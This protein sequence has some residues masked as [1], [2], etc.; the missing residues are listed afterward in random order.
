[1]ASTTFFPQR[2]PSVS[3]IFSMYTS[4]SAFTILFRTILNEI[5]PTKV[6]DFIVSRFRDFFSSYFNP[7]FTFIIEERCDYV[8]NQ[9]FRAAETYLPTLIAGISTG[10]LLVRSSNLK[11]PLARPKFGIPVKAKILDDF[12][13][14]PLEWT[15]LSERNENPPQSLPKR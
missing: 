15:L 10:S 4:L 14:I 11:N 1:M 6:R 13:G 12:E 9:T 7:N 3:E 5:I 8:T 2:I